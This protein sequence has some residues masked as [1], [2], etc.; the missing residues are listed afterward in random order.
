MDS[1]PSP[2]KAD[3]HQ[4]GGEVLVLA[5]TDQAGA[6]EALSRLAQETARRAPD[7]RTHMAVRLMLLAA[8]APACG[9]VCRLTGMLSTSI[10][11]SE[12]RSSAFGRWK[13]SLSGC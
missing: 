8:M 7:R 10:R 11:Q 6:E 4:D 5:P 13:P 1:T 12:P 9:Y 3:S 2:T